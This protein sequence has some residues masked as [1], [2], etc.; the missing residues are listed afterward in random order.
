MPLAELRRRFGS[1]IFQHGLTG[2]SYLGRLHPRSRPH[3]HGIEVLRNLPYLPT[4]A[5]DHR[6]DLYVPVRPPPS[7]ALSS[8]PEVG[9][10]PYSRPLPIVLYIH[11]GAFRILSKDTHWVPGLAFARRGF[12]VFNINYRLAP[13]HLFP[14]ALEDACAA[15]EYVLREAVRHGG[16]PSQI[17]LAGESAGANLVT[18]LALMTVV[19]RPEPWAQ[20]VFDL[21]VVPK[22][23]LPL[24]G[25]LQVTDSHRFVRRKKLPSWMVDRLMETTDFYLGP[26][27]GQ[28]QNQQQDSDP[29]LLADP[30]R[31]IEQLA[32]GTLTAAR[33]LPAFFASVGTRDPL[34]DD[35]RRLEAALKRL[36]VAHE[37]RY[38]PGE[39][40]AFQLLVFREQAKR[41]WQET[42]AFLD[43]YLGRT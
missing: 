19:R 37:A 3:R 25:M 39:V 31:L 4:G 18:S 10:V 15:F 8:S 13:R 11:G 24:C 26:S 1:L 28:A 14:S 27:H 12:L 16:D 7:Q 40:H 2:V 29:F 21:G 42:Y 32:D 30:L 20:R 17:V 23:V 41:F 9:F 22:A 38:Y 43:R 33:P 34:L 36:E 6:L 5:Q 35:T